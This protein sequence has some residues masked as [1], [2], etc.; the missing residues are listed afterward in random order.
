LKPL[1]LALLF[2]Y[3]PSPTSLLRKAA[4]RGQQ[5]GKTREVTMSGTLTA[6]GAAPRPG[7]LTMHFPS[8]CKLQAEGSVS[9]SVK[10][11]T[12]E[13]T[14]GPALKLLQLA[15]PLLTTRGLSNGEALGALQAVATGAGVDLTAGTSLSRLGDRVAYV[16][17][18]P[19]KDLS[20]P[21]LWLYKDSRAPARLIAQGGSDLRLLQ[22][23]DPAAADWFPRVL[24]LWQD[25]QLAARFEVLETRGVRPGG[26]DEDDDS[27]E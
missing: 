20:R 1:L 27:R 8:S 18:A 9:L 19:A 23:G 13:G 15:C 14:A 3:V 16:L 4:L 17:G 22:Y 2:A 10:G 24:E 25:G 7:T 5:L 11:A 26:E 21:Q 6:A 12:A